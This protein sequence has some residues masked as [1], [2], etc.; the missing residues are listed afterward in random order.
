[1]PAHSNVSSTS[2]MFGNEENGSSGSTSSSE[3]INFSLLSKVYD[4]T[5]EVELT[6]SW[7]LKNQPRSAKL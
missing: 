2:Q 1:M 7:I 5:E 4:E 6:Y 3:P